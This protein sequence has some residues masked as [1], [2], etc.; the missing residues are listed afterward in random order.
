MKTIQKQVVE[1]KKNER[2]SILK[3]VKPLCKQ[4]DIMKGTLKVALTEGRMMQ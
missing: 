3:A 2:A 4:F 1:A